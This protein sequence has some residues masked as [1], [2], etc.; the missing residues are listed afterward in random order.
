[1]MRNLPKWF[2]CGMIRDGRV[3]PKEDYLLG[4]AAF[5]IDSSDDIDKFGRDRDAI[6]GLGV[7]EN[8]FQG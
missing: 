1:M 3:V 6:M 4:R 7:M 2:Y 5:T 8:L